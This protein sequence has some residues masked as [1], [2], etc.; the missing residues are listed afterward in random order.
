MFMNFFCFVFGAKVP[1]RVGASSFTR[2]LDHT[3]NDA[4]HSVGLIWTSDQHVAQTST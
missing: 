3:H 4:P 2:F 1:Q